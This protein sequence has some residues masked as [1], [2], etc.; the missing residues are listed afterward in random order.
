MMTLSRQVNLDALGNRGAVLPD[1]KRI[2]EDFPEQYFSVLK[3][4]FEFKVSI[5]IIT[6]ISMFLISE[7]TLISFRKFKQEQRLKTN[8][9]AY[10]I[11]FVSN[12]VF[13]QV[14]D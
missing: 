10:H 11:T 14:F 6:T 9:D 1:I 2:L 5:A 13:I 7:M 8:F 3:I 4:F 12:E